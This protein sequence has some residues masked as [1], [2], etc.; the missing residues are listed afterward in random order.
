[1]E[2]YETEGTI[3]FNTQE[4]LAFW[5]EI[6]LA[7]LHGSLDTGV[8][9][10]PTWAKGNNP[11]INSIWKNAYKILCEANHIRFIGYSLPIADSY[12][13]FLLKSAVVK[14]EHLKSIDVIC[15]DNDGS[16]RKRYDEF[17][18]FNYYKFANV[19]VTEY[20][21]ML[22]SQYKGISPR[23]EMV[24]MNALEKI[25]YTFMNEYQ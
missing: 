13:K 21:T 5:N 25:H 18:E 14:T 6:P 12:I 20:L 9:V 22:S 15:L 24:R 11:K 23:K 17:L 19:D 3:K 1:M 7:K 8:I 2:N 16:V 4:D 10:P